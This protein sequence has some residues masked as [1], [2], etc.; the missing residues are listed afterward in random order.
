MGSLDRNG[1]ISL[2]LATIAKRQ[3]VRHFSILLGLVQNQNSEIIFNI[4]YNI[5]TLVREYSSV[6][7][8]STRSLTIVAGWNE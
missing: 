5:N 4:P 1:L 7:N 2:N 6:I 8:N 3:L